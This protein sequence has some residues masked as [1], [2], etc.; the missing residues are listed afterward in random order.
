LQVFLLQHAHQLDLHS[1]RHVADLVEENGSVIRLLETS[2]APRFRTG[3]C[4]AFVTEQFAFRQGF[5][6]GLAIDGDE[7]LVG[8]VAVLVNSPCESSL[9]VPV[10][11]RIR[12]PTGLAAMRPISLLNGL[13]GAKSKNTLTNERNTERLRL[14]L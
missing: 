7:R 11:P 8:A 5:R 14:V 4:A 12:T 13:H 2:D 3:E 9:P 6:D 1:G 10:S